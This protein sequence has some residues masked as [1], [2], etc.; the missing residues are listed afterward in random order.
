MTI[1]SQILAEIQ[2]AYLHNDFHCSTSNHPQYPDL[3]MVDE[4]PGYETR[5]STAPGAQSPTGSRAV[6]MARTNWSSLVGT[7]TQKILEN[8]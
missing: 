4:C 3:A 1:I 8:I 6:N 2:F 7:V 5:A